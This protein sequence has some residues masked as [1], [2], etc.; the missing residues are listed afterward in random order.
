MRSNIA[1]A[2]VSHG[3]RTE[4]SR[5]QRT[6]WLARQHCFGCTSAGFK[7]SFGPRR[8]DFPL[9]PENEIQHF[10]GV[11]TWLLRHSS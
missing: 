3:R 4:P 7:I 8:A 1:D 5:A 9:G 6:H 11:K 10:R 2:L